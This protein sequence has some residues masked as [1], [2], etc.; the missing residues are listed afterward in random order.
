MV[1][2][3]RG[4]ADPNEVQ[5]A[6]QAFLKFLDEVEALLGK[7]GG[8]FFMGVRPSSPLPSRTAPAPRCSAAQAWLRHWPDPGGCGSR[9]QCLLCPADRCCCCCKAP[10]VPSRA[11][12][13]HT[14]LLSCKV[15]LSVR[16]PSITHPAGC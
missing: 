3:E 7:H 14:V 6:Q 1:Q 5:A 13:A 16:S 15:K 8:P 9:H 12:H 2:G 11:R 4:E 10:C